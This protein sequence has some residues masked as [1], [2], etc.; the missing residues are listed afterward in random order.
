MH[1]QNASH[2]H[3]VLEKSVHVYKTY[4]ERAGPY[5]TENV[6][7]YCVNQPKSRN[8]YQPNYEIFSNKFETQYEI[9]KTHLPELNC[10]HSKEPK[11]IAFG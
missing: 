6:R 3:T 9:V 4:K 11:K 1:T 5:K 10:I 8:S 2:H 7:I